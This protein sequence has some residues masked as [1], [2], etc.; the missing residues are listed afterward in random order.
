MPSPEPQPYVASGL[1]YAF[2]AAQIAAERL[3]Y[4]EAVQTLTAARAANGGSR[5]VMLSQNGRQVQ[6]DTAADAA[7][8]LARW[9]VDLQNAE[10]QL[11]GELPVYSDR[12]VARF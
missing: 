12:A 1:Y 6:Y 5:V 4:V 2:T 8:A 7:D 3:R 11:S 10:A 9:R